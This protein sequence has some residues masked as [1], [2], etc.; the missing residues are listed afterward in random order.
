[1]NHTLAKWILDGVDTAVHVPFVEQH[2]DRLNSNYREKHSWIDG[3][4][5]LLRDGS[6]LIRDVSDLATLAACIHLRSEPV[7]LGVNFTSLDELSDELSDTPP[8]LYL[9]P[10]GKEPWIDPREQFARLPGT[11]FGSRCADLFVFYSEYSVPGELEFRRSLWFTISK[12]GKP[13]VRSNRLDSTR[14]P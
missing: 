6:H 5:V 8:S 7:P 11:P 1:V 12:D 13:G 10:K 9:F 14:H 4:L 2:V 3:A